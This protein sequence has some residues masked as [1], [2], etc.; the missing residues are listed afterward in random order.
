MLWQKL[1]IYNEYNLCRL[2]CII[3]VRSVLRKINK[4][5]ITIKFKRK[6]TLVK[7]KLFC[8]D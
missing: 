6:F 7:G 2:M 4:L 8:Y 1:N 5:M 3:Y